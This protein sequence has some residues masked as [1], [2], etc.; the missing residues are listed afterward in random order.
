M[1]AMDQQDLHLNFDPSVRKRKRKTIPVTISEQQAIGNPTL[2]IHYSQGFKDHDL[3]QLDI[4]G[5]PKN[6]KSWTGQNLHSKHHAYP[7]VNH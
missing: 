3:G 7:E 5:I 6:D 4:K 2:Q 1:Y